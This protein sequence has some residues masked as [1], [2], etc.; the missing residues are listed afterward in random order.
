MILKSKLRYAAV[1]ILAV[2]LTA[3]TATADNLTSESRY[4]QLLQAQQAQMAQA[5]AAESAQPTF[6]EETAGPEHIVVQEFD[7]F[8]PLGIDT[9]GFS[10]DTGNR[11]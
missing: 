2:L 11:K 6:T 10:R 4:K 1:L 7:G 9:G 8:G 3:G 5:N